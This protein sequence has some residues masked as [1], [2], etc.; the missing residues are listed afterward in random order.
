[1]SLDEFA[2]QTIDAPQT[3]YQNALADALEKIFSGGTHDLAGVIGALNAAG[4]RAPDG[5]AWTEASFRAVMAQF[6]A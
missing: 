2:H 3:A 5:A 1:M 6:G 4:V